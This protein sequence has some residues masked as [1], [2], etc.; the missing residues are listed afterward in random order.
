M[1]SNVNSPLPPNTPSA[2]LVVRFLQG[3]AYGCDSA[4]GRQT[5]EKVVRKVRWSNYSLNNSSCSVKYC[6]V[7]LFFPEGVRVAIMSLSTSEERGRQAGEEQSHV[8]LHLETGAR[9]CS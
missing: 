8:G 1:L 7:A 5:T 6:V 3:L 9:W 4:L 2:L